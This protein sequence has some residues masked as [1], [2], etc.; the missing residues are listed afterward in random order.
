MKTTRI[1]ALLALMM[2]AGGVTMQGQV[3]SEMY[4]L[5]PESRSIKVGDV[6]NDGFVDVVV[7]RLNSS[8]NEKIFSI[9]LN[10]GEGHLECTESISSPKPNLFMGYETVQLYFLLEDFD[11]DGSLDI[12][13]YA[14]ADYEGASYDTCFIRI[15]YNEGE[16]RFRR[17]AE[18]PLIQPE[19]VWY[20]GYPHYLS[21]PYYLAMVTGDFNGDMFPDIAAA[22]D[23]HANTEYG[24]GYVCN[25]GSGNFNTEAVFTM[26]SLSKPSVCD[27]DHD[28]K[29]DIVDA[30]L[31]LY[32]TDTLIPRE[33]YVHPYVY[34]GFLTNGIVVWDIDGDGWEDVVEGRSTSDSHIW[35]Y[36]NLGNEEF[37]KMDSIWL[38]GTITWSD[39]GIDNMKLFDYNGDEQPDIIV[40]MGDF[41]MGFSGYYVFESDGT[42]EFGEPVFFPVE[43][44]ED[45]FIR[46]FDVCDLN[47]DGYDDLLVLHMSWDGTSW[48]EVFMNDGTGFNAVEEN[49]S[50]SVVTCSPNPA[51]DF[52][53]VYGIEADE[54][55]VYSAFGQLVKT[56]QSTNEIDLSG[57]VEGIY[58]LRI[59]DAEGKVYTNKITKQ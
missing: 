10:D 25:D 6:N 53:R 37:E 58:M 26:G 27:M 12:A 21:N 54:V 14:Y 33:G 20:N 29:D 41:R 51:N 28:G 22:N 52:V 48:L 49:D 35:V 38:P 7:G 23:Y 55:Q 19:Q 32:T 39:E 34:D 43:H 59:T 24:L 9:Y 1:Y 36:R 56:V 16:G 2:M 44:V 47:G 8:A 3:R 42:F 31:I 13:S 15:D 18:T 17:F 11:R 46:N 30:P 40:Q 50:D 57:L 5:L 4:E 45:E